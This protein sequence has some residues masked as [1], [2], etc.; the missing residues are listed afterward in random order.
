MDPKQVKALLEAAREAGAS[1]VEIP[2][3]NGPL[4]ATFA[5]S[6]PEA[7][8]PPA[9]GEPEPSDRKKSLFPPGVDPRVA[10]ASGSQR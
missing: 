6:W 9:D 1:A 7:G 4:K 8:D 3:G 5:P 2:T 10:L